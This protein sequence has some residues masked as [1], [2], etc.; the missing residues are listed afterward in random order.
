MRSCFVLS[1]G[2]VTRNPALMA[3]LIVVIVGEKRDA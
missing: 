2:K 1:V 3:F